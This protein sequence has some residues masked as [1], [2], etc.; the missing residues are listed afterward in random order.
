MT[1]KQR[2]QAFLAWLRARALRY[3][4]DSARNNRRVSEL[5]MRELTAD[6]H[7]AAEAVRAAFSM[8]PDWAARRRAGEAAYK[9]KRA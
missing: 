9:G 3:L 8:Q 4:A 1:D 6:L 2:K 7:A 5:E